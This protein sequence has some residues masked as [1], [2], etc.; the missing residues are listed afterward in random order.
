MFGAISCSAA[1]SVF[2]ILCFTVA[3]DLHGPDDA[4]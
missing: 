1:D 2:Q 3:L 4:P